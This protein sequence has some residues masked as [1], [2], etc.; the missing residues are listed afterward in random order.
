[1]E[2]TEP[3]I[4]ES[5]KVKSIL[6]M[7]NLG[8]T[9]ALVMGII[10]LLGAAWYGFTFSFFGAGYWVVSAV[11]NLMAYTRVDEWINMVK[12]REYGRAKDE[13]LVWMILTIIFGLIAGVF[14][15]I[16]Y[17]YLEE[18]PR[19]NVPAEIPPPPQ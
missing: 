16:A 12:S 6:E 14:F 15:L 19:E 10:S 11:I 3:R 1:M 18:L 2:G 7:L 17:I 13:L 5:G 4:G 8:K 9:L